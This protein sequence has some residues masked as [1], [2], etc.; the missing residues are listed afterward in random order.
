MAVRVGDRERETVVERLSAHAA[1][2]RLDVTELEA[3][4][5]RAHAAIYA[6]DLRALEADLPAPPRPAP[7]R[8]LPAAP[9]VVLLAGILLTALTGH[10][11]V[12]LFILAAF[13][14]R[15][16]GPARRGSGPAPV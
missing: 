13:L 6:D 3:R 15:A 8:P 11:I 10:P 12:P 2:G 16:R 4:I 14:W 9:L 1:A 5:D 7:R